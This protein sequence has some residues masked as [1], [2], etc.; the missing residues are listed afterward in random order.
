MDPAPKPEPNRA[1]TFIA[2]VQESDD[3]YVQTTGAKIE[4]RLSISKSSVSRAL[5]LLIDM[6]FVRKVSAKRWDILD[7][8]CWRKVAAPATSGCSPSNSAPFS[9]SRCSSDSPSDS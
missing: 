9:S 1:Q 6:N 8:C 3:D 7:R 5:Q 4:R 2:A